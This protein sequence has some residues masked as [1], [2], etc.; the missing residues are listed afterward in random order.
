[1]PCDASEKRRG[2]AEIFMN[3]L[4]E[5]R[6]KN[7]RGPGKGRRT[8]FYLVRWRRA[9]E[10]AWES[11]VW[12]SREAHART[13][14]GRSCRHGS[15]GAAGRTH[16]RGTSSAACRTKCGR[17]L[18]AGG[19]GHGRT[20]SGRAGTRHLRPGRPASARS[21]DGRARSRSSGAH[22]GRSGARSS[23]TDDGWSGTGR[24]GVQ[25]WRSC[26][27][28]SYSGRRRPV[29]GSN[30]AW[31]RRS[32]RRG[33]GKHAVGSRRRRGN[34]DGRRQHGKDQRRA[35][36]ARRD[37]SA[38][39]DADAA[40]IHA[41]GSYGHAAGHVRPVGVVGASGKTENHQGDKKPALHGKS[42]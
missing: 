35:V 2:G 28:G 42:P 41:A 40:A 20:H 36:V 5:G 12:P 7:V 4:R 3:L 18:P 6:K 38:C 10:K 34:D 11:A 1:M 22:H 17:T 31:S 13:G 16:D 29:P 14:P 19:S 23:R 33:R 30:N 25:S 39:A 15:G 32:V 26:T 9:A 21:H 27:R 24:A 8:F 37:V